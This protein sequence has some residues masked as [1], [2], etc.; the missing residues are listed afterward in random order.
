[1]HGHMPYAVI[2]IVAGGENVVVNRA[3]RFRRH[4][5]GG[6]FARRF[7]LPILVRLGNLLFRLFRNVERVCLARGDGVELRFQPLVG[8]FGIGLAAARSNR[9]AADNQFLVADDNGNILQNVQKRL[10]TARY[11]RLSFGLF[12]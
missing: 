2:E 12:I 11:N 1:M 5:G 3:N 7:A 10:R 4:V 9:R 8:E 6:E